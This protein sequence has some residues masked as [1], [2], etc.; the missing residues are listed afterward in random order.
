MAIQTMV[1]DPN[2]TDD[3]TGD[4]IVAAIDAG[5]TAITRES[6]LDQDNLKLV[7]DNAQTGDFKVKNLL[8]DSSG[9]LAV[10]YDDVVVP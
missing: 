1:I 4:E 6:A 10:E 8:R 5:A 2:A 9:N 3:Q 7:K